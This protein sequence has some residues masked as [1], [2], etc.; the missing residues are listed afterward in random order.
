MSTR[1]KLG[2]TELFLAELKWSIQQPIYA[3]NM[4]GIRM[5]Q[6]AICLEDTTYEG[7]HDRESA[8][9]LWDSV[10]RLIK[11]YK[12]PHAEAITTITLN[13]NIRA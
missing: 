11:N 9:A 4:G 2:R 13:A 6:I 3:K 10:D 7:K 12:G 8:E 5:L 1:D